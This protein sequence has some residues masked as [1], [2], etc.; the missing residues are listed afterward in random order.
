MGGSGGWDEKRSRPKRG[1]EEAKAKM[2][3]D[4]IGRDFRATHAD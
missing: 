1:W 2:T 4:S 3:K